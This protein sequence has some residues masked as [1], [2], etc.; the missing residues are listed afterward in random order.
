MSRS[1]ALRFGLALFLL[2][3]WAVLG[4][5]TGDELRRAAGEGNVA[6]VKQL[7]EAGADVNAANRYGG[8]ALSYACDHGHLEVVKLL[9]EKGADPKAQDTFYNATP[10]SWA[11]MKGHV[12]ITRLLLDKVGQGDEQALMMGVGGDNPAL[13]KMILE[14]G[15]A[16]P[17]ALSGALVAA[18]QEGQTEIVDMLKA[19]GAK[20]PPPADFQVDAET[21]KSYE[22]VYEGP[23][24]LALNVALDKDGKLTANGG[25]PPFVLGAVDKVT[26]R[27]E[28]YPTLK[29]IFTVENGK[30][31]GATIDEGGAQTP[32]KKKEVPQ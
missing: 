2:F 12:E 24:G 26:F 27:P 31:T 22:G 10:L 15:K 7:L 3:P 17:E 1:Y 9:L 23:N 16:G 19:A 14:R 29:L 32:L 21:L 28:Q 25:G 6:R 20:P 8:T 5:D 11:A 30:V 18:T 4:Q 13:V